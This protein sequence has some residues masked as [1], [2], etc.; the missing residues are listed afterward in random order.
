[1]G[2]PVVATRLGAEGLDF[3]NGEEIILNDEPRQFADAVSDLLLNPG[4]RKS[5]AAA[6][7]QR[8]V[9][10]YSFPALCVAIRAAL[11]SVAPA[12]TAMVA[13]MRP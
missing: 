13:E 7:R 5:L 9:R 2:K 3:Q 10:D 4:R 8:V 6:A 1:M 11:Y 12:A